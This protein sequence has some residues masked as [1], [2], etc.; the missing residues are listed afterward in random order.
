MYNYPV[1]LL[2][3]AIIFFLETRKWEWMNTVNFYWRSFVY[4]V[5]TYQIPAPWL[6]PWKKNAFKFSFNN[7]LSCYLLICL[8][9]EAVIPGSPRQYPNRSTMLRGLHQSQHERLFWNMY[10]PFQWYRVRMTPEC[11]T[12]TCVLTH[13]WVRVHNSGSSYAVNSLGDTG[14]VLWLGVS[15]LIL[16]L[17]AVLR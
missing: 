16:P 2:K 5:Q 14:Q 6:Y 4:C 7:S 13:R 15:Q 12:D 1:G 17:K 8:L 10:S 3:C 9:R 11:S